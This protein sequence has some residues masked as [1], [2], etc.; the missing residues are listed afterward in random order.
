MTENISYIYKGDD[1][2]AF[3]NNFIMKISKFWNF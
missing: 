2:G 3:G 1:T